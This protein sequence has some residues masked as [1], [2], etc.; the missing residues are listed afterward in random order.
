MKNQRIGEQIKQTDMIRRAQRKPRTESAPQHLGV[1]ADSPLRLA[2]RVR[3]GYWI[4][5]ALL[6]HVTEVI[7]LSGAVRDSNSSVAPYATDF[8]LSRT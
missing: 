2:S 1:A 7:R 8:T 3:H 4:R 6:Q 5:S